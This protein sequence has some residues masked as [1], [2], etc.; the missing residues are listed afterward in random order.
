MSDIRRSLADNVALI[1]AARFAM[2]LFAPLTL[3]LV[4]WILSTIRSS[5]R[6]IDK[7][8]LRIEINEREI[9]IV[10]ESRT[11]ELQA[12]H[13]SLASI[14]AR[15]G[16]IETNIAVQTQQQKDGD[17]RLEEFKAYLE[18]RLGIKPPR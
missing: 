12:L 9:R 17:R 6:M 5:E 15:L 13:A 10:K 7:H 18:G 2:I 8:E 16:Q 1:L 3:A 14:H 4:V 11:Q